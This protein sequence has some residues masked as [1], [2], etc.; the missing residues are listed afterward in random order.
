M[1]CAAPA[2]GAPRGRC[3]KVRNGH[4][5]GVVG[6]DRDQAVVVGRVG[7]DVVVGQPGE[8]LGRRPGSSARRRGCSRRTPGDS[9]TSVS[10]SSRSRSRVASSRS[11]PARRKSR[12]VCS[13]TRRRVGVEAVGIGVEGG[14]HG[15]QLAV[16]PELGDVASGPAGSARRRGRGPPRRGAPRTTAA[17]ASAL[18]I[19]ISARFHVA[20]TS[21][22]SAEP[23][24]TS[25]TSRSASASSPSHRSPTHASQSPEPG[26]SRGAEGVETV[27]VS[28]SSATDGSLRADVADLHRDPCRPRTGTGTVVRGP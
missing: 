19:A 12:S 17:T 11:T 2:R 26:R 14:E 25:A 21:R 13:S 22:A 16:V 24:L 28:V 23:D 27:G 9:L 4:D 6:G 18:A 3:A 8:L 10:L 7:G 5:V 1:N 20:S 15:V